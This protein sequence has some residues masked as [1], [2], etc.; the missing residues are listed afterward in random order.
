MVAPT[1][2]LLVPKQKKTCNF[3]SSLPQ[4]WERGEILLRRLHFAE[5]FPQKI[6]FPNLCLGGEN[7][8]LVLREI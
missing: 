7:E 8:F 2:S 1:L 6:S 4:L 3:F 5:A